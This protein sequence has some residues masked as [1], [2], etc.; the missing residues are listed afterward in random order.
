MYAV[1]LNVILSVIGVVECINM[2]YYCSVF[3]VL[4][5]AVIR[6]M[7]C[8]DLVSGYNAECFV[9]SCLVLRVL[10]CVV[11]MLCLCFCPDFIVLWFGLLT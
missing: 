4:L 2:I 7:L 6:V 10:L 8:C 1:L 9:L 5:M 11:C 3:G